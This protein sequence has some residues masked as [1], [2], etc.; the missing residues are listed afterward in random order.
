[1]TLLSVVALSLYRSKFVPII[2]C[3]RN[4]TSQKTVAITSIGVPV[5]ISVNHPDRIDVS[6]LPQ[7]T[8]C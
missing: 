1:M 7:G 6:S 3:L 8:C 2:C 4:Q 5:Q